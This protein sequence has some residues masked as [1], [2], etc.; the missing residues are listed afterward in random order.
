MRDPWRGGAVHF[1]L[2]NALR[3]PSAVCFF[4]LVACFVR[5]APHVDLSHT[6]KMKHEMLCALQ[7]QSTAPSYV[8]LNVRPRG[9]PGW[10]GVVESTA[11]ANAIAFDHSW[12]SPRGRWEQVSALLSKPDAIEPQ[13][14]TPGARAALRPIYTVEELDQARSFL[15]KFSN[16]RIRDELSS[17]STPGPIRSFYT[18]S[19]SRFFAREAALAHAL[20][21][22]GFLPKRGD[23]A[24]VLRIVES[25]CEVGADPRGTSAHPQRPGSRSTR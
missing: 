17:P 14:V 1:L 2:R 8:L 25:N 24:P 9:A 20:I 15:S 19:E 21:E 5:A 10:R 13:P 16:T 4:V 6:P 3:S 12:P 23:Y 18:E 22:R 7:N 11:V